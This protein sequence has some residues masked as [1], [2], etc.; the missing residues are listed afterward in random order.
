LNFNLGS[1]KAHSL[2]IEP[3]IL[4][5]LGSAPR[6]LQFN[7][8]YAQFGLNVGY[9]Y[10]FKTSNGEHY[11]VEYDLG[12]IEAMNAEINALRNQEPQIVEK[13]VER[14]V[15]K[16]VEVPVV[17]NRGE[18]I[19]AFA[20]GSSKLTNTAKDI[21][22]QIGKGSVVEVVA[23]ASPE[24]TDA[25][26]SQISQERADAVSQYLMKRGVK[27]T[28]SRGVGATGEDSQRIARVVIQ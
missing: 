4:W 24:G 22:N 14:V 25:K 11:F 15:E 17:K 21:L 16:V 6:Q 19:V 7:K 18:V 23:T 26:N 2:Y 10:H 27:V 8:N 3:Y 5:N 20:K 12:D 28:D 1:K 9:N 13:V